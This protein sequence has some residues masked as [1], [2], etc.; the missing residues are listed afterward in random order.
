MKRPPLPAV[1]EVR[2]ERGRDGQLHVRRGAGSRRVRVH[3]P[4]LILIPLTLDYLHR[5]FG[6][7]LEQP[8]LLVAALVLIVAW[9]LAWLRPIRVGIDGI[10]VPGRFLQHSDIVALTPDKRRLRVKLEPGPDLV[11]NF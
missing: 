10:A 3:W 9:S 8:G 6:S 1:F 5:K 7:V 2:A 4:V 11:M